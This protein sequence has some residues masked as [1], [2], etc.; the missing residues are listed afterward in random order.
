MKLS[1]RHLAKIDSAEFEFNGITVVAGNNDAGKSTVGKALFALFNAFSNLDAYV[2]KARTER[3]RQMLHDA[4][5]FLPATSRFLERALLGDMPE[6][7]IKATLAKA[8]HYPTKK[9]LSP[10]EIDDCFRMIDEVRGLTDD[11]LRQAVI[12]DQFTSVFNGQFLSLAHPEAP[13]ELTLNIRGNDIALVLSNK[14]VQY[15]APIEIL[16]TAYCL[17]DPKVLDRLN[18]PLYWTP[19]VSG[20]ERESILLQ[21]L[22]AN[23]SR[24]GVPSAAKAVDAA[25][26]K[27]RMEAISALLADVLP[28][29]IMMDARRL[30]V[31]H[32]R[33][34]N[35]DVE[36]PNLS[37][38]MKVFALLSLL[39]SSGT[40]KPKDVLILD[41]P[42]VHLHPE[43][44]IKYAEAVVLLQKHYD[45]TILLTSHSSDF[46]YALQLMAEKHGITDKVNAYIAE[47]HEDG[48]MTE[49]TF[50]QTS[51]KNWDRLYTGFLPSMNFLDRLREDL[52]EGSY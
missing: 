13:A 51:D 14:E 18:L 28:G 32:D 29:D 3:L 2:R 25:L 4:R 35:A 22:R 37:S 44:Q 49:T 6:A 52:L 36:L 26:T 40:V 21:T 19:S 10:E 7:E 43:W 34:I 27:K 39:L 17:D 20:D 33:R 16:H 5:I 30:F 31:F 42:E 12:S 24:S 50:R 8:T 23:L 45:L 15:H 38:G 48:D 46:I 1:I 11:D 41:E 9:K 47:T